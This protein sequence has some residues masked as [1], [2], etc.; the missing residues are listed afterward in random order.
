[1]VMANALLGLVILVLAGDV[2][3]RGAVNVSLRLGVP[4]LIVSLTIVAMGT[5]APELLISIDAVVGGAPG[6]AIGNVVGSNIANVLLV[7]GLPALFVGL[8][9][10]SCETRSSFLQMLVG[11]VLFVAFA[12]LAPITWIHGSILL[13]LYFLFMAHAIFS[14]HRQRI[15]DYDDV[16]NVD[17]EAPWWKIVTYLMLGIIGLP[18]GA[19]ILVDSATI[20]AREYNISETVIGLTLVAIGTSLPELATTISAAFRRQADVALGNV[21]G[22]NMANLLGIIGVAAFFGDI[23]V[24]QQ[25]LSFD[26]WVMVGAT[27][28]LIPFVFFRQNLTRVWGV[29]FTGLYIAYIASVLI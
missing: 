28:L 24:S 16:E 17:V 11:T 27:L 14:A 10:S 4:A 1:M 9:T 7:L 8:G 22:S 12:F 18:L 15:A 6:I 29:V 20:I 21:I 26:I 2:L 5:S 25:V 3:V 19:D 23:P 13:G